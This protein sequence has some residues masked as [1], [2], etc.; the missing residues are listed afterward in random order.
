MVG[1][2]QAQVFRLLTGLHFIPLETGNLH[3]GLYL[4]KVKI[5]DEIFVHK[6][7]IQQ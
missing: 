2:E 3:S 5:G 7:I 4:V 6:L 1:I